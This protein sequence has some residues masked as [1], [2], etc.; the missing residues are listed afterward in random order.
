[1]KILHISPP[2]IRVP[3]VKYGGTEKV[4]Y[5]IVNEQTKRGYDVT[6]LAP[7][8]S[9]ANCKIVELTDETIDKPKKVEDV[10]C[11]TYMKKC[12]EYLSKNRDSYDIIHN[13]FVDQRAKWFCLKAHLAVLSLNECHMGVP[14]WVRPMNFFAKLNYGVLNTG[15]EK[16]LKK[17]KIKCWYVPHGIDIKD[18]TYTDKKEDWFLFISKIHPDKGAHIAV[19]LAREI[20]IKLV[21]AG[22]LRDPVYFD[23]YI[24]PYLNENIKYVGEVTSVE[25]DRLFAKAK[26][27]VF[28]AQ[29]EEPFGLVMIEALAHGTPVIAWSTAS[30]IDIISEVGFVCNSLQE[31]KNA[32]QRIDEIKPVDCRRHIEKNYTIEKAVDR[33]DAVYKEILD[34]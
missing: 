25:K 34:M 11:K 16:Y 23:K 5:D 17:H 1:M 14:Y 9:Y 27:L 30:V 28:P 33:F 31:M 15:S 29:S 7:N 26:A 6:L 8:N 21:I 18:I 10:A 12:L 20:G 3:P 32:I 4:I 2:Y 24:S 13:H 19:E 22:L